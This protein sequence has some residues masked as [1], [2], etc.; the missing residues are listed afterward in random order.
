[1][2]LVMSA[3]EV[4]HITQKK[5][6]GN[7]SDGFVLLFHFSRVIFKTRL[8]SFFWDKIFH[9]NND[10]FSEQITQRLVDDEMQ[11]IESDNGNE[12]SRRQR[13]T[14]QRTAPQST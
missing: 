13:S 8:L 14:A 6:K 12:G 11:P 9:G 3:L 1:M 5:H 4:A 2:V 10:L 7:V